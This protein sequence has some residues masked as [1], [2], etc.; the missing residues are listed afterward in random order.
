MS[1]STWKDKVKARE[2]EL[3]I[4]FFIGGIIFDWLT[5]SEPDDLS[6]ILQ[7][8]VYLVFIAGTLL[9]ENQDGHPEPSTEADGK[10]LRLWK[11]WQ[12]PLVHFSL[13]SLL[14]IYSIFYVQSASFFASALF[15]ILLGSVLILNEM[16]LVQKSKIPIRLGLFTF[17]VFSFFSILVPTLLGFIGFLSFL[18]SLLFAT[19]TL[20]GL[21]YLRN[22]R[23]LGQQKVST[24]ESRTPG[25]N[26]PLSPTQ[27]TGRLL[28][29]V[30]QRSAQTSSAVL[31]A[32]TLLYILG[33]IPPVPLAIKFMGIYHEVKKENGAYLLYHEQPGWKFW[34]D[35]DQDFQAQPND[36]VF[37]YSEIYSPAR[38]ADSV[39]VKW[40][41]KDPQQGWVEADAIPMKITGGRAE[42]YRGFQFKSN[43]S[44]GDWK[45]QVMT[46]DRREIGR[47]HFSIIKIPS[48]L[49]REFR[50]ETR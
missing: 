26:D 5:L 34:M 13:G 31:G 14:S 9:Y 10:W 44:E 8:L 12:L 48:T 21:F 36:K 16:E 38:F 22:S 7:Q 35:G 49:T 46:T 19:A 47:I 11:D 27:K 30:G 40:S 3:L 23:G 20:L 18:I 24:Q 33:W 29:L 2:T 17:C 15:L 43:F 37:F 41:Y 45:V 39:I 28:K 6:S 32:I 1:L 4:A 42:G 50:I 25:T